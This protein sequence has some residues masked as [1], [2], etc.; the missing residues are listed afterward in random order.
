MMNKLKEIIIEMIKNKNNNYLINNVNLEGRIE[1]VENPEFQEEIGNIFR[2]VSEDLG[3]DEEE[4][5]ITLFTNF[6]TNEEAKK[7]YYSTENDYLKFYGAVNLS[8]EEKDKII[9]EPPYDDEITKAIIDTYSDPIKKKQYQ[10]RIEVS[11]YVKDLT[12]EEKLEYMKNLSDEH[13]KIKVLSSLKDDKLIYEFMQKFEKTSLYV[14]ELI[15]KIEDVDIITKILIDDRYSDYIYDREI[16]KILPEKNLLE[17]LKYY[18]IKKGHSYTSYPYEELILNLSDENKKELFLTEGFSFKTK[19]GYSKE[20]FFIKLNLI[21]DL[22]PIFI[23]LYKENKISIDYITLINND[24]LR[25]ELLTDVD[26]NLDIDIIKNIF[27]SINSDEY[28]I[29]CIPDVSHIIHPIEILKSI[30]NDE[31]KMDLLLGIPKN[32][33]GKELD[34]AIVEVFDKDGLVK[35]L[36]NPNIIKKLPSV[37]ICDIAKTFKDEDKF[38]II[39]N[40]PSLREEHV[41][42]LI[43]SMSDEAKIKILDNNMYYTLAAKKSDI[44]ASLI[45]KSDNDIIKLKYLKDLL[46][47]SSKDGSSINYILNSIFPSFVNE[48]YIVSILTDYLSKENIIDK[49]DFAIKYLSNDNYDSFRFDLI[50]ELVESNINN[51]FE[52]KNRI[53]NIMKSLQKESIIYSCIEKYGSEVDNDLLIELV[54]KLINSEYDQFKINFVKEHIKESRVSGI[55]NTITNPSLVINM[56]NTITNIDDTKKLMVLS[57]LKIDYYDEYKCNL[58]DNVLTNKNINKHTILTLIN[59]I[60]NNN[61][62]LKYLKLYGDFKELNDFILHNDYILKYDE[63]DKELIKIYSD[64]YNVNYSHLVVLI[65]K[66]SYEFLRVLENDNI[67]NV[68]NTNDHDFSKLLLLFDIQETITVQDKHIDSVLHALLQ[69]DF[70]L[71]NRNI[72][73]KFNIIKNN[74]YSKNYEEVIK[75]LNDI[76]SYLN[77]HIPGYITALLNKYGIKYEQ[78]ISNIYNTEL[79]DNNLEIINSITNK[80]ILESRN[81]YANENYKEFKDSLKLNKSYEKNSLIKLFL[82]K[83]NVNEIT[84]YIKNN[85]NLFNEEEKNLINNNE[86]LE[87]CIKFKK[88]EVIS[89]D[90]SII[91]NNIKVFNNIIDKLYL[92]GSLNKYADDSIKAIYN[93]PKDNNSIIKIMQELNMN[94]LSDKLF[95]NK[96]LYDNLLNYLKNYRMIGWGNTFSKLSDRVDM[97][98]DENTI[99]SF[100]NNYYIILNKL[101]EKQ[102][103]DFELT[104]EVR[105]ITLSQFLEEAEVYAS[106]SFKYKKLFGSEDFRLIRTNPPSNA[107]CM[108]KDERIKLAVEKVKEMYKREFITIPTNCETVKVDENKE[109]TYSVGE[110]TDMMNLTYGERTGACMRIGGAGRTLF[111]FCL[112]NE[113]GFHVKITNPKT[114]KLVSR[115]SG[116]RNGNTIFLN[117]LRTSL[118]SNYSSEDLISGLRKFFDN[119]IEMSKDSEYPIKNVLISSGYAMGVESDK[120]LTDIGS[121]DVKEGYEGFYS[122]IGSFNAI[123]ISSTSET[124]EPIELGPDKSVKYKPLRQNISMIENMEEII[125]VIDKMHIIDE[126][127]LGKTLDEIILHG[128]NNDYTNVTK[129]YYGSDWYIAL[130]ENNNII[131]EYI[132]E[133]NI[134]KDRQLE[135]INKTKENIMQIKGVKL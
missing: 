77:T 101:E 64:K 100:I 122:D 45:K 74:L 113:N 103:K 102:R 40:T 8:D 12:E 52:V 125:N 60:Q 11:E 85:L 130:D 55:L 36:L 76:V 128:E 25:Y 92:N 27:M 88:G 97:D 124:L 2:E 107:A 16:L 47:L 123:K 9:N 43:K 54:E 51:D 110:T 112:K 18:L 35:V 114:G 32:E 46:V 135:E 20:D 23:K 109:L 69:K 95:N 81:N 34:E 75:D 49:A 73:N 3:V 39:N 50:D 1:L 70:R 104:K 108:S 38:K 30:K 116:F 7:I 134:D 99:A 86:L 78:F 117:Q 17:V 72:F 131:E 24:K 126:L 13:N 5:I 65:E 14:N 127:L 132:I 26:I 71:K 59:S 68:I 29:L 87:N 48:N 83:V 67:R 129:L 41:L 33:L 10:K 133:R 93:I 94:L 90:K 66:Y 62:K 82:R 21:D 98:L 28:K 53:K 106:D 84:N 57:N 115:V 22:V 31:T 63:I 91:I 111:D 37:S 79:I 4:V 105:K 15:K 56:F 19:F 118:D 96:E 121:L 6:F 80:Y 42:D 58:L 61:Y 120:V 89:L 119:I 44:V